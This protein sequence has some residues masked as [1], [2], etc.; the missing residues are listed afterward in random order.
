M[1]SSGGC[2]A[3]LKR[4]N[5]NISSLARNILKNHDSFKIKGNSL[6]SGKYGVVFQS[7]NSNFVIK[8]AKV[9]KKTLD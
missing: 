2:A 1:S 8:I 7:N 4:R 3:A 6:N 5:T 9:N